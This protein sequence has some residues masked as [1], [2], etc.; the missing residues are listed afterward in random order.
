M[1]TTPAQRRLPRLNT[2]VNAEPFWQGARD[3]KLVLQYCPDSRQFQHFPRPVSLYT[4]KRNL[5]WREVSGAGTIYAH[6]TLRTKGLGADY[7]LP[8]V[9]A[10]IELDEGV[11]IMGNI[12]GAEPGEVCIGQRVSLAWDGMDEGASYP[13]FRL[14]SSA[15]GE[16]A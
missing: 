14:A 2:F 11:R 1:S 9:L 12:L 3:K 5:E 8:L 13:A 10:T 4:G 6:T 7:R 16:P 15:S